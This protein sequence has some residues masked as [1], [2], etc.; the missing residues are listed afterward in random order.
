M[1]SKL[2][3]SVSRLLEQK[4]TA[5]RISGQVRLTKRQ[6]FF[7]LCLH[8]RTET[9]INISKFGLSFKYVDK[10]LFISEGFVAKIFVVVLTFLAVYSNIFSPLISYRYWHDDRKS[11]LTE[12]Q[13]LVCD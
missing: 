5:Q 9:E 13:I 8:L 12:K 7:F 1:T 11:H 2:P 4:K 10:V 6:T 3:C